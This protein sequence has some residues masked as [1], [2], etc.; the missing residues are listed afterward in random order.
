MTQ[1]I[2]LWGGV[3]MV[4]TSLWWGRNHAISGNMSLAFIVD[5]DGTRFYW[6]DA[7]T[8]DR[9]E[10][11]VRHLP[12]RIRITGSPRR[13]LRFYQRGNAVPAG[14]FVVEGEAGSIRVIV[15]PSGR[16]RTQRS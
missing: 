11:T 8:G 1:S 12:G 2:S 9:Y 6:T 13:P 10:G 5:R 14:T 7:R 16:I 4:E 3:R 15:S